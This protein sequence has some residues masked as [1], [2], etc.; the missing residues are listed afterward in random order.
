MTT[1]SEFEAVAESVSNWGRWG[2]DDQRGTL[3]L[4]T[5]DSVRRG[6]QA[7][8]SAVP[9]PLSIPLDLNGPQDGTGIPGRI[10][11]VRTMLGINTPMGA[12]PDVA[13][14]SDDI[15][16][17]PTQA[18]THWDA[19]SH[20]S[21]R[22]TMYNNISADAV[23]VRGAA[24]LGIDHFGPMITRGVLLDVA[25]FM[26]TERLAGGTEVTRAMLEDCAAAQRVE[27]LPGD[28]VLVRTGHMRTFLDGDIHGYHRPT[29]GLG[30]DT[31]AL[32]HACDTAAV[33]TDTIAFE[34][35][36]S[37][38]PD[39]VLPV[40]VLCLVYMGMPQGQNFNLEA[41]AEAC[42]SDGNY[43]FL[44]EGTPLPITHS[45]GGTVAPVAIK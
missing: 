17:M 4:I 36:P 22:G 15:I 13:A 11:P 2:Q 19:L 39:V 43:D 20:V 21:W 14:Y 25:R 44:F 41:L 8:R 32:F 30:V 1:V 3:N 23:G 33:A 16:V 45:T 35:L 18:A 37:H 5:P 10:N 38:V 42:A 7:V 12:S 9:V 29:P 28:V 26:G 34:L 24:Q 27:L 6:M 31:A 40:H